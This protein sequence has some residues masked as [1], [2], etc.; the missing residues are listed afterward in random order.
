MTIDLRDTF[1][2]RAGESDV[3]VYGLTEIARA[4]GV[5]AV[6][7][8]KWRERRQAAP[9]RCRTV[10]RPCVARE[11]RSSRCSQAADPIEGRDGDP[12][13]TK[14]ERSLPSAGIPPLDAVA[15]QRFDEVMVGGQ[16]RGI[17]HPGVVW[18]G[19]LQAV[20]TMGC[21]AGDNEEAFNS[22]TSMIMRR[23]NNVA[24]VAVDDVE[25]LAV[26]RLADW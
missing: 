3:K 23:A 21:V 9:S 5:E 16:N 6:L 25:Q 18:Q 10:Q 14:S 2:Q 13:P 24:F 15:Q 17:G 20:V 7:V 22:V 19:P 26:T 12:V 11:G 8:A 1:S 4:L